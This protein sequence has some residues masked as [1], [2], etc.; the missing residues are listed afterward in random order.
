MKT[1]S[2]VAPAKTESSSQT[3]PA[4]SNRKPLLL[5]CFLALCSVTL[6]AQA[7]E[8]PKALHAPEQSAVRVPP[9]ETP[10]G[11]TVI[12]SNLYT[13][14]DLYNEHDGWTVS[15]P[16]SS[17]GTSFVAIPFTPKSDSHVSEVGVPVHY[18]GSGANQVNLSLYADADGIPGTLL[19]G[20]VTVKNLAL[21]GTCCTLTMAKFAPIAVTGGLQYWV[22]ADTPLTGTG[23]DFYGTWDYV[24]PGIYLFAY[25][26]GDGWN[27]LDAI[28]S[29]AAG[30]VLGTVP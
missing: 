13:K 30:A 28:D 14:T 4:R 22:V 17:V 2:V 26:H 9:Q 15:G 3:Q 8:R 18:V 1:L 16:D 21:W 6:F 23:S 19:A 11:L 7:G 5:V 12:Y 24:A 27:G 25:S 29:E 20:P 10:A